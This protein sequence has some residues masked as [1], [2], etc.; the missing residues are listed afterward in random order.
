M[1]R[2][3]RKQPDE[4]PSPAADEWA[5]ANI[6]EA[7]L[8]PLFACRLV[9]ELPRQPFDSWNVRYEFAA[10]SVQY[11][12]TPSAG[13]CIERVGDRAPAKQFRW[14]QQLLTGNLDGSITEATFDL[15]SILPQEG[16][17]TE[18]LNMIAL[19]PEPGVVIRDLIDA[20]G[21]DTRQWGTKSVGFGQVMRRIVD[22]G[23]V[24]AAEYSGVPDGE[25]SLADLGTRP[26]IEP[27]RVPVE[28]FRLKNGD[29]EA[30]SRFGEVQSLF[31]AIVGRT[32]D[33]GSRPTLADDGSVSNRAVATV[34]LD[35]GGQDVP[36]ETS[37]AGAWEALVVST[38]VAGHTGRVVVLDE[39]AQNLHPSAQR[40]LFSRL[41]GKDNQFVLITHSPY[42]VPIESALDLRSVV[43]LDR[44][45][46]P[47][48]ART[49]RGNAKDVDRIA[50]ELAEST[51]ARALLFAAGV[52][53]MEGGTEFGALPAWFAA[54]PTA[55]IRGT[56]ED[57]DIVCFDVGGDGSFGTY[58]E[59]LESFGIPWA[60]VCDGK[61]L[62][63]EGQN[64]GK[65][66]LLQVAE[67]CGNTALLEKWR[68]WTASR[69]KPTFAEVTEIARLHGVFT[70]AKGA[71]DN[72]EAFEAFLSGVDAALLDEARSAQR[73]S[74]PRQ[75]RYFAA[76]HPEC[77]P[78]VDLLY[79]DILN[80]LGL[81]SRTST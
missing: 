29:A 39:P 5:V 69:S 52:V 72:E 41:R 49:L 12:I 45:D 80:R 30:R 50:K 64:S 55:E 76:G 54:S 19:D 56:P 28:L 2:L 70:L 26:V 51:D 68:K 16:T 8:A 44:T 62:A 22:D 58:I 81:P 73:R 74:K 47:S 24:L 4:S 17:K 6:D 66:V 37:G 33:V 35:E 18:L 65:Q 14:I 53:L 23:L 60:V 25:Y 38:L 75:G 3:Q 61:A 32:F 71:N 43:R 11:Q 34:C 78:S 15:A 77:P 27:Q 46:G 1:T 13:D 20:L 48:R 67:R 10:E 7:S 9:V 36:L 63:C 40:R 21:L 31:N 42:L 59:I 57:L 79:R